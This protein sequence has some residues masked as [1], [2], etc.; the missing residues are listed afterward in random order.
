MFPT[1]LAEIEQLVPDKCHILQEYYSNF[2][3]NR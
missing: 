1:L 3:V 2:K